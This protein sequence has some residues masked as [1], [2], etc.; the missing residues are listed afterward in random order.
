MVRGITAGGQTASLWATGYGTAEVT[1]LLGDFRAADVGEEA[2]IGGAATGVAQAGLSQRELAVDA[3][4]D[5]RG[6][7]VI[8]TIV[9]PPADGT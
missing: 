6:V 1:L 5:F 4:A 2:G 7:G 3:E 9:L 8:L